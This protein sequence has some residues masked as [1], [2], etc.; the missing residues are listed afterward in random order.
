MQKKNPLE[1][2]DL[3]RASMWKKTRVDKK[4]EYEN[5]GVREIVNL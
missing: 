4:R 2:G 1:E 3:D 5:E